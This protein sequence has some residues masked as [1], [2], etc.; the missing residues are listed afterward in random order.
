MGYD[1]GVFYSERPHS[2]G[3]ATERYRAYRRKDRVADFIEPSP[4]VGAF[5]KELTERYPR[6]RDLS[7]EAAEA[8]PWSADFES[9]EGHVLLSIVL[10]KALDT[11]RVIVDLA[12]RNG[13]ICVD[14][15]S[16]KILFAPPGFRVEF[17]E[18]DKNRRDWP[19]VAVLHGLLEPRGFCRSGCVWRKDTK[20]T[21]LFVE[22]EYMQGVD[23]YFIHLGAWLKVF[24]KAETEKVRA[25]TG[26][27]HILWDLL[28]VCPHPIQ[29]R[30]LRAL[31]FDRDVAHPL[32]FPEDSRH[33][34]AERR[35]IIAALEADIP[36]TMEWRVAAVRAAMEAYA[37]PR[38]DR[39][40]KS[41]LARMRYHLQYLFRG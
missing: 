1:L 41:V 17:S 14:P 40:E 10:S 25:H 30:F 35:E 19:L 9:S 15:Q 22:L 18:W 23:A 26:H 37:L 7:D 6:L 2:N 16:E 33:T 13:L 20:R 31:C 24:G 32:A 36:L 34:E 21:I 39:I 3:E 38:L 29:Y 28:E 27:V 8:S 4:R 12:E 5:L 11:A